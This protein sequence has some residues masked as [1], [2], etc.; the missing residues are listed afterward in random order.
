M[1]IQYSIYLLAISNGLLVNWGYKEPSSS[2]DNKVYFSLAFTTKCYGVLFGARANNTG[3]YD[4]HIIEDSTLS[5]SVCTI[6]VNWNN[7]PK[8]WYVAYG[9]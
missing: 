7:L 3:R 8:I 5:T 1:Y 2:S 6:F 4:A 9:V